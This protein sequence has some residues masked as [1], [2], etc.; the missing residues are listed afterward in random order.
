MSE[1][2][3]KRI[4]GRNWERWAPTV[5]KTMRMVFPREL[6]W[7]KRTFENGMRDERYIARLGTVND[8]F[9]GFSFGMVH[10]DHKKQGLV[11]NELNII[12]FFDLFVIPRYQ[13]HGYGYAMFSDFVTQAKVHKYDMLTGCARE[14]PSLK[15]VRK[16]PIREIEARI[17]YY[18]TG[19]TYIF[20]ALN[21]K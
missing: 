10:D 17:N 9:T 15:N 20:F 13:F 1:L 6:W 14:G 19:E 2:S 4:D 12:H 18:K 16:F 11:P 5:I 8:E 21:L 7:S 3:I